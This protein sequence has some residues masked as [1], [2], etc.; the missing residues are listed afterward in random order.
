MTALTE[1]PSN[2]NYYSKSISD[3]FL[4]YSSTALISEKR[5]VADLALIHAPTLH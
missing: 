4:I 5:P 3:L 2:A 1:R